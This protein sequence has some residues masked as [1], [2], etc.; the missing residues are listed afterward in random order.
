MRARFVWMVVLSA[1]S[2]CGGT[3]APPS[4]AKN[5]GAGD[6]PVAESPNSDAPTEAHPSLE[7]CKAIFGVVLDAMLAE[8]KRKGQPL[9]SADEV[10]AARESGLMGQGISFHEYCTAQMKPESYTCFTSAKTSVAVDRCA[11]EH[12]GGLK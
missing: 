10:K 5:A 9:P 12:L 2:G 4:E 6:S 11:N 1:L 8:A 3:N 7:Q